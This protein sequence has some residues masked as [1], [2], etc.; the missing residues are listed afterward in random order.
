MKIRIQM[1]FEADNG[2]PE[3]IE[4]VALLERGSLLQPEELGL[5]QIRNKNSDNKLLTSLRSLNP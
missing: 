3:T 2:V 1:V 5:I 4:E